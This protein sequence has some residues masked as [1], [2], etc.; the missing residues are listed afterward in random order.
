MAEKRKIDGRQLIEDL[1][2]G[3]ADWELQV[4]YKLS[5]QALQTIFKKLVERKAINH[6]ELYES[7]PFYR[8][9]TDN[10]KPR[11]H[12]RADIPLYVPVRDLEDSKTG[13]LRDISQ[14]GLRVAGIDV[15]VGQIKKFQIPIDMFRGTAS[16][17]VTAQCKWVE[18][19]GKIKQ[20]VVAGFEIIG[21]SD[22]DTMVLRDWAKLLSLSCGSEK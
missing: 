12:C 11:E 2:S 8:E 14:K 5:S 21:L 9:R 4:K 10:I 18:T 22:T 1:R 6:A 20:Y 16:L 19:K 15:T 3:M 17:A 13:L 7:S